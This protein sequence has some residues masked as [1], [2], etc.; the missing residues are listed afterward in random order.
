MASAKKTLFTQPPS[1]NKEKWVNGNTETQKTAFTETNKEKIKR[2]TIDL[3]QST[4]TAFKIKALKQNKSMLE[5]VRDWIE[6]FI[7]KDG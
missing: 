6:E 5:L 3:H 2:L 4:H 7:K 1:V